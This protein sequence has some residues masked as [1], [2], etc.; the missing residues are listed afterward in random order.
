MDG[1]RSLAVQ[2]LVEDGLE[3]R[4]KGRRRGIEAQREWADAVDEGA[5]FGV[6]GLEMGYGFGGIEGEFAA[7]AVVD[8]GR[9]LSHVPKQELVRWGLQM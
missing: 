1:G 8:H 6:G 2:L 7:A 4:F 3:E 9:S 5:E